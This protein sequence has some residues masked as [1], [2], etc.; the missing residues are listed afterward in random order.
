MSD[1]PSDAEFVGVLESPRTLDESAQVIAEQAARVRAAEAALEVERERFDAAFWYH[2][3]FR[4][5]PLAGGARAGAVTRPTATRGIERHEE[6]V[7]AG[8]D[9]ARRVADASR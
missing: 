5:Y 7:D 9:I 1:R 3:E 2:V 6:R 4:G 8:T